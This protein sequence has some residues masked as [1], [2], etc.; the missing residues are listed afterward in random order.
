MPLLLLPL[1]AY[2]WLALYPVDASLVPLAFHLSLSLVPHP[3]RPWTLDREP[4][5][6]S[7]FV[8]FSPSTIL[9]HSLLPT[10]ISLYFRPSTST[11]LYLLSAYTTAVIRRKVGPFSSTFDVFYLPNYHSSAN[12]S[13]ANPPLALPL[14]ANLSTLLASSRLDYYPRSWHP[15]ALALL[16]SPVTILCPHFESQSDGFR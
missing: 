6:P 12:L 5:T 16:Q 15:T 9:V 14:R 8:H 1:W 4:L 11:L 3:V 2:A 7:I 10:L 13:V